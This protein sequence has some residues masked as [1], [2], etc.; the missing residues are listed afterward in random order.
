MKMVL[1]CLGHWGDLN[2]NL[3]PY[4]PYQAHHRI[5]GEVDIAAKYLGD[6]GRANSEASSQVASSNSIG[7]HHFVQPLS[8]IQDSGSNPIR[9]PFL[10]IFEKLFKRLLHLNT[11]FLVDVYL[12]KLL[13]LKI[14]VHRLNPVFYLASWSLP[15]LFNKPARA[16]DQPSLIVEP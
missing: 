6:I 8:K 10:C 15:T 13:I 5:H 7:L 4:G 12:S 1:F 2:S 14:L 11:L 16:N 9:V 3:S